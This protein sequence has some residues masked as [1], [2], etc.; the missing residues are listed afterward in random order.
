MEFDLN[1]KLEGLKNQS[2]RFNYI[3][4]SIKIKMVSL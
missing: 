2:E 4:A 1:K 3:Y